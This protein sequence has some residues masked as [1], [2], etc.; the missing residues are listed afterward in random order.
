MGIVW[1]AFDERL[2]RYVALKL[3]PPERA[4]DPSAFSRFLREARACSALNHPNIVTIYDIGTDN[5]QHFIAMELVPGRTLNS[6]LDSV[7]L[8]LAEKFRIALAVCDALGKAHTAGIV[9]RD[10]KPANIMVTTDGAIKV[11]DF[12]LAKLLTPAA[13]P[14]D[15][16]RTRTL[17]TSPG[18]AIGT[19]AYMSPEQA[20]GDFVDARSDV[21]SFGTVLYQML[22]GVRAFQGRT[23]A[24]TIRM[25]IAAEPQPLL[26][27]SP[28]T[29]VKLAR[30]V[31]QCMR[32][33][34]SERYPDASAIAADLR[35]AQ[36]AIGVHVP[37][38]LPEGGATASLP[39]SQARG[40]LAQQTRRRLMNRRIAAAVGILLMGGAA[41][42]L[43]LPKVYER[44]SGIV[45]KSSNFTADA[46]DL[47]AHYYRAGNIDE[48][49]RML[50]AGIAAEPRNALAHALLSEA[51][52][53]RNGTGADPRWIKQAQA[54]ASTAV[55]LDR[56]LAAAHTALGV[57]LAE[58]G[59]RSDAVVSLMRALELEPRRASA[60]VALA[61]LTAAE[62][63]STEATGHFQT[64]A[65]FEPENW[66]IWAE[67]GIYHYRNARYEEAVRAFERAR[68]NA[69]DNSGLLRNLAAPL[70][71]LDRYDEAAGILQR[72]L[73]TLPSPGIYAQL[74]TVRFFQGRY[75]DAIGPMEKAVEGN[76]TNYLYWG[77]LGDAY[78]WTPGQADKARE[79][80]TRAAQLA[81]ERLAKTPDDSD[82][83]GSLAVYLAKVGNPS[84]AGEEVVRIA[85]LKRQTPGA[86]FKAGLASEIVGN[87]GTALSFVERAL[88]AGYAIREVGQDPDLTS[89]RG[90]ARYG[91]MVARIEIIEQQSKK[92][93]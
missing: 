4:A 36:L 61:K 48:A 6:I 65:D 37:E 67:W 7:R 83:R 40:E 63:K 19:P 24:D 25:V 38:V 55:E 90:D 70:I 56:D 13:S 82:L 31:E 52:I 76:A 69:P 33:A 66:M 75:A 41:V 84:I 29:P 18:T 71:M 23:T 12:G 54:H 62:G 39:R 43:L 74:G 15:S 53:R 35:R 89:L 59:N 8:P 93:Q 79:A 34:S 30:V 42:G 88:K 81:R 45:R 1:K 26:E 3:L 49:V 47:L 91:R 32:K 60:K 51:F 50:E 9:H 87:R 22:T 11:L 58:A 57:A 64:A 68:K 78:R 16:D 20:V 77:N 44:P 73:E 27:I 28:D 21:F 85:A 5:D 46:R 80:F 2:E 17:L 86:L 92:Q 10:V 72:A 14:Q